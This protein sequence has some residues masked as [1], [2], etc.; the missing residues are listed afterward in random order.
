[1]PEHLDHKRFRATKA[2]IKKARSFKNLKRC[3]N[4]MQIRFGE[5]FLS[6]TRF[7][8]HRAVFFVC[9]N[10][11]AGQKSALRNKFERIK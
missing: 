3:E 5:I 2:E 6:D 10:I 9:L 7:L 1:M 8:H 4:F 11:Q